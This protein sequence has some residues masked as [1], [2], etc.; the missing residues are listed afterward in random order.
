MS[1]R[2]SPEAPDGSSGA[3]P[4]L[5]NDPDLT[6]EAKPQTGRPGCGWGQGQPRASGGTGL[7]PLS[8]AFGQD[9]TVQAGSCHGQRP[10]TASGFPG[11]GMVGRHVPSGPGSGVPRPKPASGTSARSL[12][13]ALSQNNSRLRNAAE[14][15]GPRPPC[16][17]LRP[18][19]D[20]AR[21]SHRQM[22]SD[23]LISHQILSVPVPHWPSGLPIS[24]F[25]REPHVPLSRVC[26]RWSGHVW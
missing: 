13:K 14:T 2:S 25:W 22:L 23:A 3:L 11:Q 12:L 19:R 1:A 16:T 9:P 5:R 21:P 10:S 15:P 8:V 24:P 17:S 20:R 4:L 18:W 26:G 7:H 6:H